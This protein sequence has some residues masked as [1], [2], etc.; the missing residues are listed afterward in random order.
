YTVVEGECS[1]KLAV[2]ITPGTGR[3]AAARGTRLLLAGH[4]PRWIVSAGFAGALVPRFVRNDIVLATEIRDL[5]G[6]HLNIDVNAPESA[7]PGGLKT[8]RLITVDRIIR[9][10]AE[11]AE[12][13][14]HHGADLVDMESSA[15]AS[16]CSERGVRFL[17]IRVISDSADTD[18][19]PE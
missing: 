2:L 16:L 12:L 9:T 13:G 8:G 17:S 11:K 7:E 18:L 3:A 6:L 19:P 5:E 4:R 14:R 10:A 15:V 1:G